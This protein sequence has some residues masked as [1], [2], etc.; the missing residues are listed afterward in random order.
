MFLTVV[1]EIMHHAIARQR[2]MSQLLLMKDKDQPQVDENLSQLMTTWKEHIPDLCNLA[3]KHSNTTPTSKPLDTV[4][5]RTPSLI[6][7]D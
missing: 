7:Q 3:L 4:A 6:L 2:A 5:K 1:V